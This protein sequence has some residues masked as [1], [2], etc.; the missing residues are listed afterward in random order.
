MPLGVHEVVLHVHDHKRR[1]ARIDLLLERN[2]NL[3]FVEHG[4]PPGAY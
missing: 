3:I 4:R 2:E 1:M